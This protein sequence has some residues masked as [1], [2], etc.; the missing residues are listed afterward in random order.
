MGLGKR[1]SIFMEKKTKIINWKQDFFVH[2]RII[3][4]VKRGEFI[5][6]RVSYVVLRDR[7]CNIIVLNVH[8]PSQEKSEDLKD[9]L[10]E[11]LEQF[12]FPKYHMKIL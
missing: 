12:F 2:H 4:P 10:Y 11:D 6:D 3:S 5:S 7:W 1:D 8:A 9:S